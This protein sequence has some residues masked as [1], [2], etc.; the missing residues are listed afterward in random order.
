MTRTWLLPASRSPRHFAIPKSSNFVWAVPWRPAPPVD[1]HDVAR[2]D[3]A[4][5]D[6][7]PV[8]GGERIGEIDGV[9]QGL[10]EAEGPAR[11]PIGERLPFAV[12]HHQ[13]VDAVLVSHVVERAD[14]RM[15]QRGDRPRLA[16]EALAPGGIGHVIGPRTLMATDS[17]EAPVEGAIDLAHAAAAER[18]SD[19]VRAEP[20]AFGQ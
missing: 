18:T 4:M 15:V 3:V 7:Q 12:L 6:P 1:E 2:L 16:I 17:I 5:D 19:L 9:A 8:G 20:G 14:V 10:V 13:E 11:E